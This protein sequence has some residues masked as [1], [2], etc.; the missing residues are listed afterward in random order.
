MPKDTFKIFNKD[1]GLNIIKI[2]IMR[3]KIPNIKLKRN[4]VNFFLFKKKIIL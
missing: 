3:L 1:R 4:N 2:P